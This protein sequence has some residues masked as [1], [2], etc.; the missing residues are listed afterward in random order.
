MEE[1][2]K[3]ALNGLNLLKIFWCDMGPTWVDGLTIERID[4]N[5]NYEKNN[6]KWANK[7]EQ[8]RNSRRATY[9]D[10]PKGKMRLW[11]ASIVSGIPVVTLINRIKR[12]WKPEDIFIS[13]S[14]IELK[15]REEKLIAPHK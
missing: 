15:Y 4:N 12:G 8:G 5:G 10:T 13:P 3:F 9:I 2:Y 1:A 14:P 11:E 6:C 7:L